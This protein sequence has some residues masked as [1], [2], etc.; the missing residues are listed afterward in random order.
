M[1]TPQLENGYT[2]I[3]N[4]IMDALIA[5]RIPGEERQC[6]DFIIRKT[7]GYNKKDDVISNSQFVKATGLHKASV[8][9]SIKSLIKKNIVSKSANN[10][11]PT[12]RFNKNYK[13]WKVL[14]KVQPVSKGATTVSRSA[15]KV[16]A[17]VLPTKDNKDNITKESTPTF[18][19]SKNVPLPENIFLTDKM[20]EYVESQG[21]KNGSG[22]ELL[23]D[24]KNWHG[25]KGT[26]H[27]N[28]T[29]AFQ[30]WVRKDKLY[31]PD[32]YVIMERMEDGLWDQD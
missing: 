26:L 5:F 25:A 16:L 30:K 4:E 23:E 3:A 12:Y 17:E 1:N 9:R 10:Y 11:I 24:F 18:K 20:K 7:Y 2:K 22:E 29:M 8:H 6:L 27:K 31:H 15:N 28:W 32:K 14:A 21:G 13:T 19:F